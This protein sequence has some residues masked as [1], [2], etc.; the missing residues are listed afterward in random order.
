MTHLP[1]GLG[2]LLVVVMSASAV[3]SETGARAA[4]FPDQ[5]S[6]Y[7][8]VAPCRAIDTRDDHGPRVKAVT[9]QLAEGQ[10]AIPAGARAVV[11]SLHVVAARTAGHLAAYSPEATSGALPRTSVL[12]WSV[13]GT[14]ST[15]ATVW[16]GVTD[17]EIRPSLELRSSTL[18]HLVVD[19]VGYYSPIA[20]P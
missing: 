6:A 9:L 4:P 5:P 17:P 10:C 7:F 20:A 19:V 15:E 3:A 1:L 12:S 2:A 18:T 16:L 8:G 11:V 14:S 13:P